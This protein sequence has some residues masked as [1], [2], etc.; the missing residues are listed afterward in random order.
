LVVQHPTGERK[1]DNALLLHP[2][3]T[4]TVGDLVIDLEREASI[5]RQ[6]FNGAAV[7]GQVV[8]VATTLGAFPAFVSAEEQTRRTLLTA[9]TDFSG[10][11]SLDLKPGT[12]R[13][14]A[15]GTNYVNDRANAETIRIAS[16]GRNSGSRAP[17]LRLLRAGAIEGRIIVD[18]GDPLQGAVV[19]LYR[20]RSVWGDKR[21]VVEPRMTSTDDR[22]IFRLFG[23][24]PAS[25]YVSAS[26]GPGIGAAPSA[27]S[28]TTQNEMTPPQ[29][30]PN[31]DATTAAAIR[32]D[33]GSDVTGIVLTW[34]SN[35]V[36]SLMVVHVVDHA[37]NVAPGVRVDVSPTT[38]SGLPMGLGVRA[39]TDAT[40]SAIVR[41]LA[42][43][44]YSVKALGGDNVFGVAVVQIVGDQA[45]GVR[46][47][48]G[49]GTEVHG[50][51]VD[52]LT[53][54]SMTNATSFL[55]QAFPTKIDS[56]PDTGSVPRA[57]PSASGEFVL[58]NIWGSALIRIVGP[59]GF[60]LKRVLSDGVDLTD[61]PI[62]FD[63]PAAPHE[64]V[65]EMGRS[66]TELSGVV[67]G[68]R[69]DAIS[70]CAVVAVAKD[71]TDLWPWSRFKA[72]I[73]CETNS[74]FR[75]ND[76]PEGQYL[77]FAVKSTDDAHLDDGDWLDQ[78]SEGAKQVQLVEGATA[79]VALRLAQ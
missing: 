32:I 61:T 20:L 33:A 55:V 63:A 59:P 56:V 2:G 4:A 69:G 17:T 64:L 51:V 49:Y 22:G 58:M 16:D 24:Q 52:S 36:R 41:G 31:G 57:M 68:L 40:G 66:H 25:Y 47:T 6:V 12:Y 3:E 46:V 9:A 53:G 74:P 71:R 19:H 65:V 45:I 77:V 78:H 13:L 11:F 26:L 60:Y 28:P 76:L 1:P 5:G 18:S 34:S 72:V 43:G 38:R 10:H 75:Y 29:F 14:W 7:S 48:M 23:L 50:R 21:L 30:Y 62:Q 79:S 70:S 8:D 27:N 37:G 67:A 54:L 35:Q 73:P 42:E 44:E 39:H 15:A